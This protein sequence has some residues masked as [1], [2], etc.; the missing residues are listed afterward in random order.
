MS[1]PAGHL[2]NRPLNAFDLARNIQVVE[3]CFFFLLL[4][5]DIEGVPK[6]P[7]FAPAPTVDS[8][9]FY[10][11]RMQPS[12]SYWFKFMAVS[13]DNTVLALPPHYQLVIEKQSRVLISAA[14]FSVI[15]VPI[16]INLLDF[17]RLLVNFL[18]VVASQLPWI[19][20]TPAKDA[21]FCQEDDVVAACRDG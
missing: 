11:Q 3:S 14:D 4:F 12:A 18:K 5:K 16:Y 7:P 15:L 2:S 20:L 13:C 1:I 19:I 10:T 8:A 9:I 17:N 6:L 21:F